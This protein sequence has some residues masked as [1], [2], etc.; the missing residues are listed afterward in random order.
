MNVAQLKPDWPGST[1]SGRVSFPRSNERGS[2]EA[3][4]AEDAR[5]VN[6]GFPRS[7]E[8]GS[9]EARTSAAGMRYG[10]AGFHVRMNVAQLKRVA[11]A[12]LAGNR[13]PFPRSNERGS[14]EASL[15]A[16]GG[17]FQIGVSTFE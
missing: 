13:Q 8:R 1:G 14:I 16:T 7:N 17:N 12:V 3:F 2:I 4:V 10:S 15:D 6:G 9:I 5:E 11:F